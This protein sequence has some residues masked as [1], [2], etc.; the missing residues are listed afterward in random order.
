MSTPA[1]PPADV[2]T[3]VTELLAKTAAVLAPLQVFF[4]AIDQLKQIVDRADP[5]P[6]AA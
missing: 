5:S 4:E 6:D 1:V 3:I 2:T